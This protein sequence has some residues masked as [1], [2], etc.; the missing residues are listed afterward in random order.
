MFR[1]FTEEHPVASMA[2][3]LGCGY[4]L[5]SVLGFGTALRLVSYAVLR[6]GGVKA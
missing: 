6:K 5:G 1:K 4:I 2:V 3:S